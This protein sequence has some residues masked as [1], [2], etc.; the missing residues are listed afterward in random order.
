MISP[1]QFLHSQKAP[2]YLQSKQSD[3]KVL[4]LAQDDNFIEEW[5]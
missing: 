1:A 3:I 5:N 2:H 4:S